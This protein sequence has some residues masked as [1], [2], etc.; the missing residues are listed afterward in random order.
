MELN[1]EALQMLDERALFLPPGPD[2]SCPFTCMLS[3]VFSCDKSCDITG[4][5]GTF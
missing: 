4:C 2:N 3:C 5:G 1:I